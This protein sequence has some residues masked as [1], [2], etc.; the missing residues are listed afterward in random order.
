MATSPR[1]HGFIDITNQKI[2]AVVP[3]IT[4]LKQ[5]GSTRTEIFFVDEPVPPG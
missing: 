4:H 2:V 3:M 5:A 1:R